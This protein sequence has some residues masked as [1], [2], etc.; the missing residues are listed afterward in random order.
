MDGSKLATDSVQPLCCYIL[1]LIETTSVISI[2]EYK[3]RVLNK[4]SYPQILK[5]CVFFFETTKMETGLLRFRNVFA[6]RRADSGFK[7]A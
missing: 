2:I 4:A 3:T 7:P 1:C 6:S 5:S